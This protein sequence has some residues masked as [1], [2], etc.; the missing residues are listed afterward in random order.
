MKNIIIL[1]SGPYIRYRIKQA[2][3]TSIFEVHE[4]STFSELQ[5]VVNKLHSDVDLIIMDIDLKKEDGFDVLKYIRGRY[6]N[7]PVMIL[8]SQNTKDQVIKSYM[9]G[10]DD[11][12]LK[13]FNEN[14]LLK[15]VQQELIK[16]TEKK[17]HNEEKKHVISIENNAYNK[18]KTKNYVIMVAIFNKVVEM[19]K[20]VKI[21]FLEDPENIY[22][23]VKKVSLGAV[24]I[25]KV[26]IQRYI[27]VYE[28]NPLELES[29]LLSTKMS[30]EINLKKEYTLNEYSVKTS[31]VMLMGEFSLEKA[32]NYLEAE[33][34]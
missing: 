14:T 2:L 29:I 19:E 22:N 34:N 13:P 20:D 4:A 9:L 5:N 12:F 6:E 26:G 11:Y 15:R 18:K 3:D 24:S 32:V 1:D 28:N 25:K 31:G 23:I 10:A 16:I 7:V 21:D 17:T 8:T 27:V 30:I 33:L